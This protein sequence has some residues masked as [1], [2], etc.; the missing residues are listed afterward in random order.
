MKLFI[1]RALLTKLNKSLK[2]KIAS[3]EPIAKRACLSNTI[4]TTKGFTLRI[5]SKILVCLI[6]VLAPTATFAQP[7]SSTN[8]A[9]VTTATVPPGPATAVLE[10]VLVSGEQPGPGMWKI[11]KGDNVLWIVGIQ[12]PMPKKMTWRAKIVESTVANSQ[13]VLGQPGVTVSL[14]QIGYFRALTLIPS[15]MESVKNPD[16]ATLREIVPADVYTRWVALRSKYIGEYQDDD[17]DLERSRPMFAA[18]KLYREAISKGGMTFT[19][20]VTAVI[21][22]AAK[23]HNVKVTPVTITPPTDNARS[24]INELKKT[25]LADMDCFTKTIERIETDLQA[26]RLRAN[27]WATGDINAIRALP[28]NDQR[29][30]CEAAIRDAGFV[31]TLGVQN[32]R[33]QIEA[34]WMNAAEAA[35]AKNRSTVATLSMPELLATD[36]YLSKLK[37]KGYVVEEPDSD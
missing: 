27:A 17:N 32:L 15:A 18:G 5:F 16:G 6:G 26:M 7:I 34:A 13:E 28:I 29:A 37:A 19:S 2:S 30:A 21:N 12:L 22:D 1:Q 20:P 3:D 33:A 9:P 4:E 31:K 10:T 8:T 35:L 24:A 25:R 23:K 14:K 36:G 11:S